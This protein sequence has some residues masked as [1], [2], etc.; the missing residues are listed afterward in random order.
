MAARQFILTANHRRRVRPQ[1]RTINAFRRQNWSDLD[2]LSDRALQAKYR[3][4]RMEI[5]RLLRVVSPHIRRPTRRNF[6]LSP[7]VQLLATLRFYASGSFQEVV[8]DATGLSK[9]SVSRCV[10]AVTPVLVRHARNHIKMPSTREEVRE[11]HRGFHNMAGIPR[12]LG[13]VDG[14]LIPLLNP[15]LEDPCWVCR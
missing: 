5:E 2:V 1:L 11:V 7:K 12:V 9:A 15:E 6:A 3:L 13:V 8:G 10:A 4:P 14:T